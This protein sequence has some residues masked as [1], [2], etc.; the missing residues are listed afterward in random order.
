[1][2]S[3]VEDFAVFG[4]APAFATTLH[5][6]RPNL[7]RRDRLFDRLNDLLDRR[8][9]SNDGPYV[10]ELET[11]LASRLGVRHA[12]A[13][14]NGTVGL[15]IAIRAA[16]LSGEIIVPSFTFVA[17][18]HVLLWQGLTPIFCD[19]DPAT[20]NLSPERVA[21]L[22][23]PR[24]TGI[25]GVHIWGRASAVDELDDIARRHGLTLLYDAA[26]A[27]LC[28]HR[29]RMIGGFGRAEVFSFHATKFVNSFEGGAIATDDD[30]LAQRARL[31]RNFGFTDYDEVNA[32]GTNGKMSEASAAMGL[33]SLESADEFIAVNRRNYLAYSRDLVAVPGVD[34]VAYA[35]TEH[36][37]YQYIVV[38]VDRERAGLSRDQLQ[39]L[40]WAENI[41]VRR[42][43]YP[44]CHR[45]EPYRSMARYRGLDLPATDALASRVLCLPTGTAVDVEAIEAICD[46]I[47]LAVRHGPEIA[48]RL[49]HSHTG[50]AA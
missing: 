10:Q 26:H 3:G 22:I 17:T 47:A 20:H 41:G 28:S 42:Y 4:G 36:N 50:H 6:G 21:A 31:M 19:V 11:A 25:I 44:G 48:R 40:L 39:G 14:A 24:V 35:D 15:D 8:W 33:T 30:D 23:T 29:G 34:L 27:L 2:K 46:V 13:V 5:V 49:R 9:L 38:E 32:L 18:S 45:M 16:G 7:G 43:F 1:M 12:I 37:N